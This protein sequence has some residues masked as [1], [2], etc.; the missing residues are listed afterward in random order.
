M[1]FLIMGVSR[2]FRHFFFQY[3]TRATIISDL[4]AVANL[5]HYVHGR[6]KSY[7]IFVQ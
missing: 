4:P 3:F 7:E 5:T 6:S 2:K 1:Y